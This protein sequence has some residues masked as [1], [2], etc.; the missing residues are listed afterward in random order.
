M[1][2]VLVTR[3]NRKK[4]GNKKKEKKGARTNVNVDNEL[5]SQEALEKRL[6]KN[7]E[8]FHVGAYF[9]KIKSFL[10]P[11]SL[12]FKH[13]LI[14]GLGR[15]HTITASLQLQLFF[16]LQSIFQIPSPNCSFYD[17]A[18]LED[19]IQFLQNKDFTLLK[20]SPKPEECLE[21][22]LLFMPHCPTS[23]Y[24]QWLDAYS[25]SE[26][27]FSMCG[28][29]L[30]LYVDNLPSKEIKSKYPNIYRV[31]QQKLH[32]QILFPEFSEAF[33]FNDFAFH[34]PC[35]HRSNEDPETTSPE[36]TPSTAV[37]VSNVAEHPN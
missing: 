21:N 26:K 17:P 6:T 4:R 16:E 36:K 27:Q 14:L 34:F 22:T 10:E 37:D 24:E 9:E 7:E 5:W 35:S 2:F 13:C 18:F 3:S 23:L 31:C 12:Q 20:E 25:K 8:R 32:T 11:Y 33:A 29:N 30:K 1:D 28:N 19:D 15:V